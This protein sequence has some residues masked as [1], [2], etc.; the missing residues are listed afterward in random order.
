M[1]F[2]L[3]EYRNGKTVDCGEL[4][5]SNDAKTWVAKKLTRYCVI[6]SQGATQPHQVIPVAIPLAL[7]LGISYAN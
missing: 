1:T 2:I 5:S 3:K 7:T 6:N 4:E